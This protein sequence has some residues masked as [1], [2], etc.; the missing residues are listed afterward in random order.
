[1][2]NIREISRITYLLFKEQ[3][4]QYA[5]GTFHAFEDMKYDGTQ[6]ELSFILRELVFAY[7]SKERLCDVF[8][9]KNIPKEDFETFYNNYINYYIPQ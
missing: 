4:P 1:M 9:K 3:E 2:K 5:E 8:Q 7:T 6:E